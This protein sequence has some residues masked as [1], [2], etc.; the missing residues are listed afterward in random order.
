MT[1][2]KELVRAAEL[3]QRHW[4]LRRQRRAGTAD[5]LSVDLCEQTGLREELAA[6]RVRRCGCACSMGEIRNRSVPRSKRTRSSNLC[7]TALKVW[8]NNL[9]MGTFLEKAHLNVYMYKP[10][11]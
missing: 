2:T 8:L 10:R 6:Y 5:S 7:P 1:W 11:F 9:K 3:T 4:R